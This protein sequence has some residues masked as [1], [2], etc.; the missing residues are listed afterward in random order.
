MVEPDVPNTKLFCTERSKEQTECAASLEGK[1]IHR[2]IA[3]AIVIS[4][5]CWLLPHAGSHSHDGT[6][7]NYPSS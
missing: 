7:G 1:K 2:G 6:F 5:L 3:A 4:S